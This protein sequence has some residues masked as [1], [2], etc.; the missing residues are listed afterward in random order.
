[1][2][3]L[4]WK[5]KEELKNQGGPSG[6]LYN[7]NSFFESNSIN[8]IE[9]L[10][11][12][13]VKRDFF[14]RMEKKI[15]KTINFIFLSKLERKKRSLLWNQKRESIIDENY[16]NKF[17]F[18][19]FHETKQLYKNLEAL[20]KCNAKIV[21]TSHSPELF[22][23]EEL[24]YEIGIKNVE[25][26]IEFIEKCKKY[27]YEAFKNADYIIFPC[28]EA[29]EP[30]TK[31]EKLK[32]ILNTK[33]ENIKFLL[34]GLN[35]KKIEKNEEYFYQKYNIPKGSKVIAYIGRHNEIKGY[36]LLVK[37]GEKILEKY[38]NVYFIIAGK[39]EGKIKKP[40]NE[41]WIEIGWTKEG[42]NIMKNCDLFILPNRETYF[43]LVFLELLSQDTTIL[44]SY[45]GGNKF[46]EKYRSNKIVFFEK[47]NVENLVE[48]FEK[49]FSDLEKLK[50]NGENFKI[51]KENFTIE[52]FGKNYLK[53]FEEI[54]N[55]KI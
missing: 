1:M 17:D 19:H 31:D 29:M 42:L 22:S 12:D 4:I 20:K 6:Y 16:L 27:D 8:F 14:R 30:Y 9:Y 41:R 40:N 38:K 32:K 15:T 37:A 46:F 26:D 53:I 36:D 5:E 33:R 48:K 7:L 3:I 35:N 28:E 23:M 47:E 39:D 44:C 45:T 18:I 55:E 43:D 13:K 25:K 52:T 11:K 21:L 50:E 34:T 2:K 54:E 10:E 49:I 51:F 24:E